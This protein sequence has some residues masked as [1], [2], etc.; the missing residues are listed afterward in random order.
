MHVTF[1]HLTEPVESTQDEARRLL[2][3]HD[4]ATK[5]LAVVADRQTHGRGT[6][7]R[8]WEG[9]DGRKGNLYLTVCVPFDAIPVTITLLPLQIAVLVA[10]CVS[11][12]VVDGK[13]TVKWPNDVLVDHSKISGTLIESEI[14]DQTT[15]L[16]I[17]VGI[18]VAFAPNLSESPGKQVR[19]ATCL[20]SHTEEDLADSTALSLGQDFTNGLVDWLFDKS[21]E[22]AAKEVQVID[23]WKSFAEFGRKYELRATRLEEEEQ[24]YQGEEVVSIDIQSDGQLLVRGENGRERLLIAD[25]TF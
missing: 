1:H 16:L 9:E 15:W 13:T 18:N 20:Q 11:K 3:Q 12:V 2:K 23:N 10:E 22:K 14:V 19:G 24:C 25:Y 4:N 7:G 8:K 6:Q 17:G 5:C 21:I